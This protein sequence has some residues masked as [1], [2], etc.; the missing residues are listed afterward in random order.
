MSRIL[1]LSNGTHTCARDML[2]D[3]EAL[4]VSGMPVES[5]KLFASIFNVPFACAEETFN[6]SP[7]SLRFPP[8]R[9]TVRATGIALY[10]PLT[11]E[12]LQRS[13]WPLA[14]GNSSALLTAY[15]LARSLGAGEIEYRLGSREEV[16]P[17]NF[18]LLQKF[19]ENRIT[20]RYLT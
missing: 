10:Y 7:Q 8:T 1:V 14:R 17:L 2:R 6:L 15:I 12:W 19:I 13:N 20:I 11:K 18:S 16:V 5:A 9:T 3:T 4:V